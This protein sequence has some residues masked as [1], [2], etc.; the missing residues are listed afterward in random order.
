[1]HNMQNTNTKRCDSKNYKM[2]YTA[3]HTTIYIILIICVSQL[4]SEILHNKYLNM[5]YLPCYQLPENFS[6]LR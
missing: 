6:I 2:H 5:A 1:M 3:Q 4:G